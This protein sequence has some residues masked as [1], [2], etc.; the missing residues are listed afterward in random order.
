MAIRKTSRKAAGLPWLLPQ[1]EVLLCSWQLSDCCGL[2]VGPGNNSPETETRNEHK[3]CPPE[4][5]TLP[6]TNSSPLKWWFPSPESPFPGVYFQG[7]TVSFR[8]GKPSKGPKKCLRLA[9]HQS[10]V[11]LI[12]F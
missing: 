1:A 8:E 5:N 3:K 12:D 9:G 4:K 11:F 10:A 6:E 7:L 2:E